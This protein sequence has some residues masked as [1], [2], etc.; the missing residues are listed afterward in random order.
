VQIRETDIAI[1]TDVLKDVFVRRG[2]H[3]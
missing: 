2:N 3:K 1:D